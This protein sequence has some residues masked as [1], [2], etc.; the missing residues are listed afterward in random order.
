MYPLEVVTKKISQST[1]EHTFYA[2]PPKIK[3]IDNMKLALATVFVASASAFAP[4][5]TNS[6]SSYR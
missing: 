4:A 2:Q 3:Y 5:S 1:S 6:V